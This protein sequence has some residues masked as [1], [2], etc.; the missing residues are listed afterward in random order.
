MPVIARFYGIIFRMFMEPLTP[1]KR[2]HFHAYYHE[3]VVV[4]GIDEVAV[5]AGN[6][7]PKQLRLMIAWAKR[8]QQE[9]I[10]NWDFLQNGQMP[11]RIEA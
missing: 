6:I 10:K 3:S 8:H 1:H 11:F 2:P 4:V 9:L 7:P 5:L